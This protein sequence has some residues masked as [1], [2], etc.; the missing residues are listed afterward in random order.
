MVW[1]LIEDNQFLKQVI[2]TI[3]LVQVLSNFWTA[4]E[5]EYFMNFEYSQKFPLHVIDFDD[6]NIS[7]S[8]D[9]KISSNLLEPKCCLA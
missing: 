9:I 1:I 3:S 8:N 2:D 5:M 4:C 6:E 7:Y